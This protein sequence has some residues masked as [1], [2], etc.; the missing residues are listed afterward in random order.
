MYHTHKIDND[1]LDEVTR[2]YNR[3]VDPDTTREEL[4][5]YICADW[6]EGEDHQQWVNDASAAE[7]VWWLPASLEVQ[8][9]W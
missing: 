5:A 4:E 8:R 3:D 1:K 2:I 6:L 9:Y 7:I